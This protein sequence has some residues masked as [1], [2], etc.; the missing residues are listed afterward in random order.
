MSRFARRKWANLYAPLASCTSSNLH[1]FCLLLF[2]AA[3]LLLR[4]WLSESFDKTFGGAT[5]YRNNPNVVPVQQWCGTNGRG[6]RVLFFPFPLPSLKPNLMLLRM[7]SGGEASWAGGEISDGYEIG[8]AHLTR[9]SRIG[10]PRWRDS[11]ASTEW[12][13]Y[14]ASVPFVA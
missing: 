11:A 6:R 14:M 1:V 5:K 7:G 13:Q 4:N 9:V 12:S 3:A 2:A 10:D 8:D